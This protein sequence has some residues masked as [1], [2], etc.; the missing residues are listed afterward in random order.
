MAPAALKERVDAVVDLC[1]LELVTEKPIGKLS[2]GYRQRVGMAQAL[3]HDPDVLIMDEP[4]AGS[5]RTRSASSARTSS[6]SDGPRP[7]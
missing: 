1:A 6:G 5:I 2:R 4:T 3:L 7:C